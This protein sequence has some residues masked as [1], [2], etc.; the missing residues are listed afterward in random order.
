VD[1]TVPVHD[2]TARVRAEFAVLNAPV[3]AVVHNLRGA[4]LFSACVFVLSGLSLLEELN[5]DQPKRF[6][7]GT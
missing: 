2:D 4:S 5:H 6:V 1:N 7:T 3:Q